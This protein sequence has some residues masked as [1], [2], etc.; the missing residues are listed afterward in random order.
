[1]NE[2]PVS[3]LQGRGGMPTRLTP[4]QM[5]EIKQRIARGEPLP[6]GMVAVPDGQQPPPGAVSTGVAA[7]PGEPVGPPDDL[8]KFNPITLDQQGMGLLRDVAKCPIPSETQILQQA[9]QLLSK[10]QGMDY[11]VALLIGTGLAHYMLL[12]GYCEKA[13]KDRVA[14][15]FETDEE[16]SALNQTIKDCTAEMQELQKQVVECNKKARE[17]IE[18]RWNLSVEKYGLNPAKNCYSLNE[19]EGVIY[20]LHLDCISCKGK[21]GIRKSRQAVQES[22]AKAQANA[23]K[24][25]A[26]A[27]AE[28]AKA[29][30]EEQPNE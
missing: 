4:Q 18:K 29:K 11:D 1:M 21:T 2:K 10:V 3:P 22:L 13:V 19:D 6:E 12:N 5:H 8:T 30:K 26:E 9:I 25:Q 17:A 7:R 28:E 20:Q 16:L 23:R 14:V 27:Q 24:K 15:N